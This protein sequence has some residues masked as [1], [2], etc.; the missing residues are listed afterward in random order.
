MGEREDRADAARE[1]A[2]L[3]RELALRAAARGRQGARA[4]DMVAVMSER[5]AREF[6]RSFRLTLLDLPFSTPTLIPGMLW[7]RRS[8]AVPAHT[9]LR[10]M[11]TRVAGLSEPIAFWDAAVPSCLA[12]S[13]PPIPPDE[14]RQH[15]L[16]T[17][18]MSRAPTPPAPIA[19]V[20]ASR[21]AGRDGNPDDG[22]E[23]DRRHYL[24]LVSATKSS[25]KR[26]SAMGSHRRQWR[27]IGGRTTQPPISAPS[28]RACPS[29]WRA[30]L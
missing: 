2:D 15:G 26:A 20:N 8:D 19:P 11:V 6:A 9:W 27:F 5:A 23:Q 3:S 10:G 7:H 1:T 25:G 12:G 16:R 17:A 22:G 24:R 14:V 29:C 4:V 21:P 28:A 13:T 30:N 18:Q